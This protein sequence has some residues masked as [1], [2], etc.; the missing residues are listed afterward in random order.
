MY[1]PQA[2]EN[3]TTMVDLWNDSTLDPEWFNLEP[4]VYY[5]TGLNSCGFIPNLPNIID[6]VDRDVLPSTE[7]NT[8]TP[9]SGLAALPEA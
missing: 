9:M 3:D 4:D 5:T 6:E 8:A 1:R 7:T 2:L